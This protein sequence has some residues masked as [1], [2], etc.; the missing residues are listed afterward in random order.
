M[1]EI[2]QLSHDNWKKDKKIGLM[3]KIIIYTQNRT[4]IIN[5][6][7]SKNVCGEGRVLLYLVNKRRNKIKNHRLISQNLF[8]S[9]EIKT[10]TVGILELFLLFV[11]KDYC[12]II[13]ASANRIRFKKVYMKI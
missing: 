10:N 12:P 8:Q 5:T 9:F 3:Q 11:T 4:P 1:I 2:R 6:N 13:R 7:N